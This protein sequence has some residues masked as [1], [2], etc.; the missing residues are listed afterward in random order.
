[1]HDDLRGV[2]DALLAITVSEALAK[3]IARRLLPST[4]TRP[5]SSGSAWSWSIRDTSEILQ[6]IDDA[7]HLAGDVR[8][9][10]LGAT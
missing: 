10:A 4:A 2:L 5:Q 3:P 7:P 1:M 6:L 9:A 8:A